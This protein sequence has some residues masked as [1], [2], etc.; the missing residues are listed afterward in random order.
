MIARRY[1]PAYYGLSLSSLHNKLPTDRLYLEWWLDS[2][3]IYQKSEVGTGHDPLS[4]YRSYTDE[5]HSPAEITEWKHIGDAH[6]IKVQRDIR[7]KLAK[8]FEIGLAIVGFHGKP[9]GT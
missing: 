9:D 8:S 1:I 5:V 4:C 6:A 2:P 7:E 3:H